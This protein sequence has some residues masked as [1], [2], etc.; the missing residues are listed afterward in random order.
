[1][2]IQLSDRVNSIK[3]SP[4]LAVAAKA[5]E[6]KAA[7]KDIISLGAGEPDFA[8]PEHIKEAAK[9]AIDANF[10]HY[11][12]VDGIPEL[13][14]AIC[15][16]F[17]RDNNLQYKPEQILVSCG[18]KQS[19]YN[20]LQA[21]LNPG[22]EV[23]IPTPYWVS[24]TDMTLLAGGKPV[25][26]NAD[27]KQ[28]FKIT[29]AQ[30]EAALTARTR[31]FFINSPNNPSGVA[32]TKDELAALGAVLLKHPK[33][34]I[35]SDDIY[36]HTYWADFAFVNILNACPELYDRTLIVNG[37]SKAYSMTGWRIGYAAGPVSVIKAMFKIQ[38]QST[39]NP[40]SISQKAA[41]AALNGDQSFIKDM[42]KAFKE[43]HDYFVAELKKL[44]GVE[45]INAD[46][47]FYVLFNVENFIKKL[48]M[49]TVTNDHEFAEYLLNTV[50]LAL[51]PG[52]AFGAPGYLR[53]SIAASMDQL[54][55]AIARLNKVAADIA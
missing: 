1:M 48:N 44:P 36:E 26:V 49:S 11:T 51:V 15:A 2:D 35:I 3:P 33:V 25:L 14:Q 52:S 21:V 54:K 22:D 30:L 12:Q 16:K 50:G 39:T 5:A 53:A 46:G 34:L 27:I 8:T 10:T 29:P 23:V 4:T 13:K 43:R 20:A 19:I 9:Q 42:N 7:G 37:V 38:G 18:A 41:V 24:Y 28:K 55:G 32:Y 47:A 31:V 40:C 17:A 45:C 6:L